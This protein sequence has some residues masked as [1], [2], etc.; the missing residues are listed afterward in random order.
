MKM[1]VI[2]HGETALNVDGRMQGSRGPNEPLTENGRAQITHLRDT[3][4]IS[5]DTIYVSPLLRAMETAQILNERFH[6]ELVERNELIE[7]DFGSLSGQP[8]DSIS[9]EIHERDLELRYDYHPFGGESVD[10]VR[11]R[12]LDFLKTLA[13]SEDKTVFVVT[14]RGVIRILYELYP[15][16]VTAEEIIPGSKHVFHIDALPAVSADKKSPA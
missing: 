13:L 1:I 8:H 14:H 2:R 16:A 10:D 11:K 3:L 15:N 9:P 5:P 6:S 7:R 4:L 12:T